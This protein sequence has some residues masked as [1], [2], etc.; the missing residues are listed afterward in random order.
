MQKGIT[1]VT[2]TREVC[3]SLIYACR[4]TA[5]PVGDLQAGMGQ[6]GALRLLPATGKQSCGCWE[7]AVV[8]SAASRTRDVS[9]T[10]SV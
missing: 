2:L 9:N 1:E 5:A 10:L 7:G 6:A 4:N 8:G 3:A